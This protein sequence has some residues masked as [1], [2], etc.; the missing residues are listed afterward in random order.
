M[1]EWSIG[2]EVAI[3]GRG[4]SRSH[5]SLTRVKRI[6]KRFIECEDGS[7]FDHRGHPYPYA[8]DSS[9]YMEP[10]TD[11]HREQVR[12]QNLVR[13]I[14]R[15][16]FDSQWGEVPTDTLAKVAVILKTLTTREET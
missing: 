4:M 14:E 11:Q 13:Y 12:R 2:Q 6:M 16:R 5:V 1:G 8:P 9:V 3:T 15:Q 7:K 10:A